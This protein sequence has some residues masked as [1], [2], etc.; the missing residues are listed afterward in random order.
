MYLNDLFY[1]V[2]NTEIY[3]L[4][5]T[6]IPFYNC[7][8]KKQV[9][10]DAEH[11]CSHLVEWFVDNY[12]CNDS[13]LTFENYVKIIWKKALPMLTVFSR[14]ENIILE[15]KVNLVLLKI[16]IEAHFSYCRLF[17]TFCDRKLKWIFKNYM[18]RLIYIKVKRVIH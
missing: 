6:L 15:K 7:C 8:N 11:H 10:R 4:L 16:F 13:T 3:N 14:L 12:L 5:I 9:I 2:A 18:H 17:W 1:S